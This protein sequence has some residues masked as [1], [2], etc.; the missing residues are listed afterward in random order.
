MTKQLKEYRN[1]LHIIDIVNGFVNTSST[2]EPKEIAT[3]KDHHTQDFP[4]HCIEVSDVQPGLE[5]AINN[6]TNGIS[7]MEFG[8]RRAD[9]PISTSPVTIDDTVASM[10]NIHGL[11]ISKEHHLGKNLKPQK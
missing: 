10:I 8:A 5:N 3:I 2:Q 9:Y 7:S 6:L 4:Q 1:L 11:D